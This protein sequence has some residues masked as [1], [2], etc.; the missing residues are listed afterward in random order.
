MTS[1]MNSPTT[2]ID[3]HE[4]AYY[5]RL[6]DTW[7]DLDGPFWPLHK[8]NTLRT[9]FL[10]EQLC[11]NF[12]RDV[13]AA[14]PLQGLDVLD[15]GCG[16]GILSEAIASL[17]ARVH[18]IDVVTRNI[19]VGREHAR[20]NSLPVRYE[21]IDAD[22]LARHGARYDVVLNMEVV[23]HVPDPAALVGN[24]ADLLKP[25]GTLALA[26]INR[27]FKAWLFAIVGAEYIMGWLPRGTHQWTRFMKPAELEHALKTN[28]LHVNARTGVRVNP[29]TR[30][31]SL[32]GDESVNFMLIARKRSSDPVLSQRRSQATASQP[33]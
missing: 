17:G 33:A 22:R 23:E 14:A 28:G 2:N 32:T 10:L 11:E 20:S 3:E 26:T 27:S 24:C 30:V 7:W 29:F 5:A 1:A 9:A 8:L 4:T 12:H 13:K 21:T 31:F 15:V 16:G 6:A 19:E 25:G 18:G